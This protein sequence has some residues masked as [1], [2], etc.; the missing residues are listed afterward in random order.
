LDPATLAARHRGMLAVL[1][2]QAVA[3]TAWGFGIGL[4]AGHMFVEI[5]PLALVFAI[6]VSPRFTYRARA[7]A[8]AVGLFTESALAVHLSGGMI[9]VHFHYFVMLCVLALYGTSSRWR[10]ASAMSSSSTASWARCRRGTSSA[11]AR[12][13]PTRG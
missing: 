1:A 2:A 13:R 4:S 9:V 11:A 5:L 6:A 10:S 7:V 12:R 3:L 8:M